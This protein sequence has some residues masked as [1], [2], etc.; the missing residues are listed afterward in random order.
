MKTVFKAGEAAS[1]A[2]FLEKGTITFTIP[3]SESFR[4]ETANVIFG[5]SEIFLSWRDGGQ[6]VRALT[7]IASDD[8]AFK[9]IPAENLK[10]QIEHYNVGF[11]IA[12]QIA[13]E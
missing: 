9:G 2:F 10:K 5:A 8:A 1:G 3:E 12:R 6:V 4:L 7:A 11:N 13:L